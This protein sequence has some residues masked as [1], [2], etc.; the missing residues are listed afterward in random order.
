MKESPIVTALGDA[1]F[2]ERS[3]SRHFTPMR[4]FETRIVHTRLGPWSSLEP[5]ASS[6]WYY[7]GGFWVGV[8]VHKCTSKG[9]EVGQDASPASAQDGGSRVESRCRGKNLPDPDQ[10]APRSVALAPCPPWPSPS[11]AVDRGRAWWRG[12]VRQGRGGE[13]EVD[14][15]M[16]EAK[17]THRGSPFRHVLEVRVLARLGVLGAGVSTVDLLAQHSLAA[18]HALDDSDPLF[19]AVDDGFGLHHA[20]PDKLHACQH[21]KAGAGVCYCSTLTSRYH[22]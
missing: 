12:C 14:G 4:P 5:P 7:G 11:S 13:W 22:D 18:V 20:G 9:S 2:S 6:L 21:T 8:R 10:A 17:K 16:I 3:P 19:H 15:V 1:R